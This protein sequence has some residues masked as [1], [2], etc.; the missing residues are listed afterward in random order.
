MATRKPAVTPEVVALDGIADRFVQLRKIRKT[1]A[2]WQA[3]EKLIISEIKGALGDSPRG[4]VNGEDVV[5]WGRT[6]R[7][8]I[9][10]PAL[11]DKYPDVADACVKFVEVRSFKI[12][13]T[14]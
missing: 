11:R 2:R 5:L 4:T 14:P 8:Q 9:D 3:A 12:V 13:D 10:I 6:V 7:Q 1:L